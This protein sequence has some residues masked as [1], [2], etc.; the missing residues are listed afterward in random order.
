[1]VQIKNKFKLFM[2]SILGYVLV[3]PAIAQEAESETPRPASA[4]QQQAQSA[5]LA[6]QHP[7]AIPQCPLQTLP[8]ACATPIKQLKMKTKQLKSKPK[9]QKAEL[10]TKIA[11]APK[12]VTETPLHKDCAEP[13]TA[14]SAQKGA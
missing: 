5:V 12:E 13:Q 4:S 10:C 9:W 8:R 3:S 6:R 14:A 2:A 1:M 11:F 7:A